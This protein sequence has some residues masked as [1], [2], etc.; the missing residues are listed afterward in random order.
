MTP[1]HRRARPLLRGHSR[2]SEMPGLPGARVLHTF[3]SVPSN[4][5]Y[6]AS[7]IRDAC[8]TPLYFNSPEKLNV[9]LTRSVQFQGSKAVASD[10]APTGVVQAVARAL[11]ILLLL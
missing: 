11:N 4:H 1:L 5:Q 10:L 3:E 7:V 9:A 2:R 8:Y 6:R